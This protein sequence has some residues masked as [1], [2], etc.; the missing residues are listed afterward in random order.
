[1][2]ASGEGAFFVPVSLLVVS[3][4]LRLR[5]LQPASLLCPWDSAGKDTGVGCHALFQEIFPSQGSNPG[6]LPCKQI[7]YYLSQQGSP[8]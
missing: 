2:E 4:S 1:M 7:L 5:R 6:L 3:D 8:R